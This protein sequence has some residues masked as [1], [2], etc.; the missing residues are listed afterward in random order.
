MY[1]CETSSTLP[2]YKYYR[3]LAWKGS[4][5][6]NTGL[7]L[8][9]YMDN[10]GGYYAAPWKSLSHGALAYDSFGTPVPSIRFECFRE[11]ITD[12][13]Y[14]KKLEEVAQR[15]KSANVADALVKEAMELAGSASYVVAE[16]HST[17]ADMADR[18]RNRAIDLILGIQ[19]EL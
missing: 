17:D 8:F 19:K 6:G 5:L 15:A 14:L 9:W 1:D 16:K 10:P 2:L 18:I 4:F 3:L 13:K 11:G 12:I 7:I